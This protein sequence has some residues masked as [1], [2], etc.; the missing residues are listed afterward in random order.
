IP[1]W[2]SGN[3]EPLHAVYKISTS[4]SAAETALRKDESLIV[5]MIKRL[6]EVVYVNT[7]ELKNFDQELITF[8][9]INNQEDLKTAKKLKSKM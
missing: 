5:D 1:R 4:I 9:N 3:I 2:P 7:D 8:F 6:D